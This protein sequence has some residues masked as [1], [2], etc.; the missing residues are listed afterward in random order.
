MTKFI[1]RLPRQHKVVISI[2]L[3]ALLLLALLP[4][5]QA[6][7]SRNTTSTDAL[8]LGKRYS[9]KIPAQTSANPA[10]VAAAE[11]AIKQLR[12]REAAEIADTD[13]IDDL[14]WQSYQVRSGIVWRA[15]F[16]VWGL[17]HS[18]SIG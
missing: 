6:S 10:D 5:E 17:A 13:Y 4:S 2:V 9:L 12:G 18:S 8:E 3:A 14:Q 7:A 1:Y 11:V 15:F 16:S